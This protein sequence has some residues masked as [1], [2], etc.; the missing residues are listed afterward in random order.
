VVWCGA[1][2]LNTYGNA[3]PVN[4]AVL[5]NNYHSNELPGTDLPGGSA[6]LIVAA[7]GVIIEGCVMC[8]HTETDTR[9]RF[10]SMHVRACVLL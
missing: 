5:L 9:V 10:S 7:V 2:E 3:Y 1:E 6:L 8:I 4:N